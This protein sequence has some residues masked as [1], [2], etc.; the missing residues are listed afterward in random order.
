MKNSSSSGALVFSKRPKSHTT[1]QNSPRESHRIERLDKMEGCSQRKSKS[2]AYHNNNEIYETKPRMPAWQKPGSFFLA[3]LSSSIS[4]S[5]LQDRATFPFSI[6]VF[7][8][9]ILSNLDR[10]TLHDIAYSPIDAILL[11]HF[12]DGVRRCGI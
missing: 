3:L 10:M 6:F 2:K 1:P 4:L 12:L 9:W 8:V 5:F 11:A 7:R